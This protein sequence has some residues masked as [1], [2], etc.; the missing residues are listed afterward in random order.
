VTTLSTR[1]RRSR[2][3]AAALSLPSLGLIAFTLFF[4]RPLRADWQAMLEQG[5]ASFE[6]R[7]YFEAIES[8]ETA[9]AG[10]PDDETRKVVKEHLGAAYGAL[11]AESLEVGEY[12]Q[13][14]ELFRKGLEHADNYFSRFGL[15]FIHFQR[16][17]DVEALTHLEASLLHQPDFSGAHKLLALLAYRRGD[18]E[19]AIAHIEKA[20][21]AAPS[22]REASFLLESWRR[23]RELASGFREVET[24][25]FRVRIDPS[26]AWSVADFLVGELAAAWGVLGERTCSILGASVVLGLYEA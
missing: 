18:S 16:L 26:I 7:E 12:R 11:G 8:F 20:A 5:I 17:E 15:G 22:D 6:R 4:A 9:L 1:P 2:S 13:A 23:E 24:K 25:H 3:F 10:A 19:T 14:E 21:K